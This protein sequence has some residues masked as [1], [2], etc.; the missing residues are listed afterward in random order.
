MKGM[1]KTERRPLSSAFSFDSFTTDQVVSQEPRHHRPQA[2]Q[3]YSLSQ[4]PA[5]GLRKG[6]GAAAE[7][8]CRHKEEPC[9]W[10]GLWQIWAVPCPQTSGSIR[11]SP[12]LSYSTVRL[13]SCPEAPIS[14]ER[15]R[16]PPDTGKVQETL[17]SRHS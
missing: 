3:M 2:P 5:T 7:P 15:S 9:C 4:V 14:L 1:E 10:A 6:V 13:G 12:V 16:G 8:T 11:G 17:T